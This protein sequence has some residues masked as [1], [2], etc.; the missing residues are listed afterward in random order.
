MDVT[1]NEHKNT[2]LSEIVYLIK[3][4]VD[5]RIV[6][7]KL[8][9][10][11]RISL[12]Y[13]GRLL[14]IIG[15]V[16][17]V[18]TL[19][20]LFYHEWTYLGNNIYLGYILP[21]LVTIVIG[22]ILNRKFEAE[23]L[24]LVQGLFFT[25]LAWIV[26]SFLCSIPF[27]LISELSVIDSFFEAVSGFTTTGMTMITDLDPL[28]KSLL[29]WRSLIQWIGGLGILSFF[30]FIGRKGISEH[31][32]YRGESHKVRS[33]RPV[34]NI[35]RTIRYL[36]IIFGGLTA[37][38]I[39]L[40]RLEG[41]SFFDAITHSF[42][43]L[44][45]GGFSTHD[46]SIEYFR[47]NGFAHFRLIEYTVILFMFFG[48]TNFVVHYRV[49][50][51][52]ITS[53]WDNLEMKMWWAILGTST[54]LIM[55]EAGVFDHAI[56][57]LFR[58][59][60]FQVVSIAT[61]TGYQTKFIGNEFFGAAA[62][63]IFLILMVIGGCV[64]STGGGIKVKRVG[65]MLK[66]IWNRIKRASRPREMLTPLVVDGERVDRAELER[67][68]IIFGI[69]VFLIGAGG[70]ITTMFSNYGAFE[71]FSGVFSALG[72]IGPSYLSPVQLVSLSAVVKVFYMFAM[73]VG[74]LEVLPIVILLNREVW[75]S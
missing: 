50:K 45:T 63:Q 17:L 35:G 6:K 31:I 65:I 48:G 56:E 4:K 14:I 29:F 38:M 39:L 57:P 44:S 19:V 24:D 22:L 58:N 12:A 10:N 16:S 25:G 72:N 46:A 36:W 70:V 40:L 51:G 64:S 33:S 68:F 1:T 75:K 49:L 74:R 23:R 37:T 9:K 66:G 73:L 60:V 43:T 55:Y 2:I 42:T 30:L 7:V 59:T 69:W 32:L 54:V 28:P 21:A 53:L 20:A 52:K 62:K 61:T 67:V 71:S 47:A 27:L 15:V 26:I 34:P 8:P 13:L 41:V 11:L 3:G 18:P 5:S